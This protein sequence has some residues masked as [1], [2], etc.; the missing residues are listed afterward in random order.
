MSQA[1]G[2]IRIGRKGKKQFAFGD[3]GAPGSEP[4][5]VDVVEVFQEWVV[6]DDQFR[7]TEEDAEGS[8]SIPLEELAQFNA[9]AQAFVEKL[10]GNDGTEEVPD[11]Y[12]PVT[13]AEARDFLAR[14]REQYDELADFFRVKSRPEPGSPATSAETSVRFSVEGAE[15]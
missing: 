5:T 6:I 14:L 9:A 15:N 2:I 12:Q 7:T 4:F 1:N 10:R 13:V 3:E 11:G 8:R